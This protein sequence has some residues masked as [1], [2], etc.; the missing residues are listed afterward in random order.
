M[1][2]RVVDRYRAFL[3]A[4]Q[5]VATFALTWLARTPIA[6]VTLGMLLH[7]REL[8]GSFTPAGVAVGSYFVAMACTA[9][10][11][12]RYIDRHGPRLALAVT[13]TVSPLALFAILAAGPF[14]LTPAAIAA[15]AAVAGAFAPPVTTLTRASLR[16]RFASDEDR[17]T[18]FALDTVLIEMA[19]ALGPLVIAGLLA[20]GGAMLA[21]AFSCVLASL[22]APVFALSP[23]PKYLRPEPDA[24]RHLL[25]PL[26]EP[27][28]I[29]V[30]VV[31]FFV[32]STF[33]L[34]EVAYPAFGAAKGSLAQGATLIAVNSVGS[35]V[36]GLLYGGLDWTVPPARRL[37]AILALM[38][39]P[40]TLQAFVSHVAVLAVL[41]FIGGLLIAPAMT[42]VMVLVSTHAP[43]RYA[44]E[45]FTW[46]SS[47]IVAGIGAGS[48]VG[49]RLVEG[50]GPSAVFLTAALCTFAALGFA[51]STRGR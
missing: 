33:G 21:F 14:G 32:T 1:L 16:Q 49:G 39:I 22:A 48:A 42:V 45:A 50:Y 12:G 26:T 36:G 41:A 29:A 8:T 40:V 44:T 17:N 10:V 43:S 4:P 30:F 15:L 20:F 13:G 31:V 28:L 7:V 46:A 18:A 24:Q 27:R 11:L 3:R 25:G 51:W 23:A 6:T 5:L 9:P 34:L 2:N 19:F 35:A 47:G 37:P 38:L